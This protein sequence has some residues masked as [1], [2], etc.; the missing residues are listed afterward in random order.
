MAGTVIRVDIVRHADGRSKGFGHVVLET[1][2]EAVHAIEMFNGFEY[3][4]RILT[5][6]FDKQNPYFKYRTA[7]GG[8]QQPQPPHNHPQSPTT[9]LMMAP[10]TFFPVSTHT[11]GAASLMGGGDMTLS[12]MSPF[13]GSGP[14]QS[15]QQLPALHTGGGGYVTANTIPSPV[16]NMQ[17]MRYALPQMIYPQSQQAYAAAMQPYSVGNIFANGGGGDGGS[18]GGGMQSG[19]VSALAHDQPR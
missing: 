8:P 11:M 9:P 14:L 15:H 7:M 3:C 16:F 5:V 6:Q 17:Q 10:P 1:H 12:P 13:M 18:G 4:G 2:E 19:D